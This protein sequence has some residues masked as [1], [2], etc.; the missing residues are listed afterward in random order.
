MNSITG[1]I[2]HR[3]QTDKP[4]RTSVDVSRNRWND[5][6]VVATTAPN[7]AILVRDS[8]KTDGYG[9]SRSPRTHYLGGSRISSLPL[10]SGW[11]NAV[12]W[13]DIELDLDDFGD[14]NKRVRVECRA[15]SGTVQPRLF[16][17]T[18][19]LVVGTGLVCSGADPN[20]P[21]D[22]YHQVQSFDFVASGGLRKFRLQGLKNHTMPTYVI[23]YLEL[24]GA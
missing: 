2:K 10:V 21:N 14:L 15:E 12:D 11:S 13:V 16:D 5:S 3:F 8:S 4:N 24:G 9:F 17:V 18:N 23:G 22:V 6:E 20:Y 19:N 1:T 7:G